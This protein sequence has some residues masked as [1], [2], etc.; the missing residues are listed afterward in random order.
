VAD[1]KPI[2]DIIEVIIPITTTKLRCN[3][4]K[5]AK[6]IPTTKASILV[7]MDKLVIHKHSAGLDIPTCF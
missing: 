3:F 7:A 5:N 1:K 2:K 4:F 6:L